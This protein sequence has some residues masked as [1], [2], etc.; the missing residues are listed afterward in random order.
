MKFGDIITG[1]I[2]RFDKKG[3]GVFDA[4]LQNGNTRP[5]LV[6][7]TTI[8][9]EVEASFLKRQEGCFVGKLVRVITPGPSRRSAI[10]HQPSDGQEALKAD[11]QKP[12]A[13]LHPGTLWAHINYDD[14]IAFKRVMINRAME[15]AGHNERVKEVIP[16]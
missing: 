11:R 1:T 4:P 5:F 3:R 7:F 15:E 14:Q 6:P 2:T 12:E 16:C 8:G 13:D 10:N 9:D